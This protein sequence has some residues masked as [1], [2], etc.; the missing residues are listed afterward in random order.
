MKHGRMLH[1]LHSR[2]IVYLDLS[3][4]E[5]MGSMLIMFLQ[6]GGFAGPRYSKLRSWCQRKLAGMVHASMG[7][8]EFESCVGMSGFPRVVPFTRRVAKKLG[9][10]VQLLFIVFDWQPSAAHRGMSLAHGSGAYVHFRDDLLLALEM[11]TQGLSFDWGVAPPSPAATPNEDALSSEVAAL[12]IEATVGISSGSAPTESSLSAPPV[13]VVM[14]LRRVRAVVATLHLY[15]TDSS[16]ALMPVEASAAQQQQSPQEWGVQRVEL[17]RCGELRTRLDV[18]LKRRSTDMLSQPC[19]LDRHFDTI[20]N[21]PASTNARMGMLHA[22][23]R[24]G[25]SGQPPHAHH[26]TASWR[27]VCRHLSRRVRRSH[28]SRFKRHPHLLWSNGGLQ[29]A[30]LLRKLPTP[31]LQSLPLLPILGMLWGRTLQHQGQCRQCPRFLH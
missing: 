2:E 13:D 18:A 28:R 27:S 16:G 7:S 17:E 10:L 31:P 22:L 5:T 26:Q 3:V 1:V 9:D 25:G 24:C 19:E 6:G 20:R 23:C 14:A 30:S 15:L 29:P 21:I 12:V 11:I 4:V 8:S